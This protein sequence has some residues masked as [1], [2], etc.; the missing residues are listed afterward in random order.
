[1]TRRNLGLSAFCATGQIDLC[2]NIMNPQTSYCHSICTIAHDSS[3]YHNLNWDVDI[4]WFFSD[5]Q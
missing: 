5:S 2:A 1:M 3:I 4:L